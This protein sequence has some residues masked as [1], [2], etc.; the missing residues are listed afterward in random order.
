MKIKLKD[1]F[2]D[3]ESPD[4]IT[5]VINTP[6]IHVIDKKEEADGCICVQSLSDYNVKGVAIQNE[7]RLSVYYHIFV[8]YSFKKE[9][10]DSDGE[11][12][13]FEPIESTNSY[14]HC[15][16][17]LFPDEEDKCWVLLI[18]T[19][20]ARD[21]KAASQ[22]NY[23]HNMV[24]QIVS[25]CEYLRRHGIIPMDKSVDAIVSFPN[26]IT[27][28]ESTLFIGD[29]FYENLNKLDIR[30]PKTNNPLNLTQIKKRY[31]IRIKAQNELTIG[32]KKKLIY[33]LS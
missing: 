22:N 10:Y 4:A 25:T 32:S 23:P 31:N 28:Y 30:K 13:G 21:H 15:E 18:E 33:V 20:Y 7:F 1:F 16:C 12:I 8:E 3:K 2:S 24:E 19:K 6:M 26:L 29:I 27:N 5:G 14:R 17:I 11:L 9:L